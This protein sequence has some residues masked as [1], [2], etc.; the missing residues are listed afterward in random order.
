MVNALLQKFLLMGLGA[1]P[2]TE[3]VVSACSSGGLGLTPQADSFQ[4]RLKEIAPKIRPNGPYHEPKILIIMDSAPLTDG[5]PPL[6]NVPSLFEQTE[7]LVNMLYIDPG[8]PTTHIIP[9]DCR[10]RFL[11][12]PSK[13]L[14]PQYRLP[15]I[16]TPN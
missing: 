8:I 4:Q 15:M 16:Q 1:E 6:A 5:P 12:N 14:S 11:N 13:C 3:L 2:G 10:E 7:K 9:E